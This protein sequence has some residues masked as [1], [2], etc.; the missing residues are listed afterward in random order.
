MNTKPVTER[1]DAIQSIVDLAVGGSHGTVLTF[2]EMGDA[3]GYDVRRRRDIV[4]AAKSE[5]MTHHRRT[6]VSVRNVGYRVA[7]PGEHATIAT[8]H[9]T[10]SR[11]QTGRALV[12]IDS[13]DQELL[14]QQD[15]QRNDAMKG[16]IVALAKAQASLIDRIERNEEIQTMLV[17]AQ[18]MTDERQSILEER[19]ARIEAL[20]SHDDE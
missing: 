10:R 2:S 1:Q 12:T 19:L 20:L 17:G 5:L 18:N 14:S 8:S 6:L 15:R 7:H 3:S 11:R 9:L 13:A 4:N 16:Q